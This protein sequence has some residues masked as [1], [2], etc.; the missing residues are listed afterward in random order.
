MILG[1]QS[2]V[3]LEGQTA[4]LESFPVSF[5][6]PIELSFDLPANYPSEQKPDYILTCKWLTRGQVIIG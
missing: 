6:P 4:E 2:V 5:L 3:P 1:S